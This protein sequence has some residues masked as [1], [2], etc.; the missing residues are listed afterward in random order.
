MDGSEIV[1]EGHETFD[2]AIMIECI[3]SATLFVNQCE[4][5][6]IVLNV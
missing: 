2:S 6:Q 4:K 5:C 1:G 3:P